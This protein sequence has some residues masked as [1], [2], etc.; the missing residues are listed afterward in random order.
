MRQGFR[1]GGAGLL[2]GIGL[3][4]GHAMNVRE[5]AAGSG[6]PIAE[7]I[8]AME[9]AGQPYLPAAGWIYA[10]AGIAFGILWIL[11]VL[12][13]TSLAP[14]GELAVFGALL[15]CAGP[16]YFVLSFGTMMSV[17]D[18]FLTWDPAAAHAVA[19]PFYLSLPIGIALSLAA[20]LLHLV[21]PGRSGR[22]GSHRT[23]DDA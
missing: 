11:L 20:L 21:R 22:S 10:G 17:G 5:P 23:A 16:A 19:L 15:A 14:L 7:T 4:G 8:A 3:L 13:A 6:R 1:W 12:R 18:T 2:A 9:A